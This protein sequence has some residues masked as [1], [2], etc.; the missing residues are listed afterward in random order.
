MTTPEQKAVHVATATLKSA[1]LTAKASKARLRALKSEAKIQKRHYKWARKQVRVAKEALAQCR[2][3]AEA[4]EGKPTG[5]EASADEASPV[6]DK[7]GRAKR[8]QAV[9]A[10]EQ[11][12]LVPVGDRPS[13]PIAAT[14]P[15][16][17]Q[18]VETAH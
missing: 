16:P 1:R 15:V 18:A 13:P 7:S 3:A 9:L 5:P 6:K 10:I 17:G 11:Q 12:T 8:K 2:A 4:A 14:E